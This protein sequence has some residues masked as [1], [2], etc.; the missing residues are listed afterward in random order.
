MHHSDNKQIAITLKSMTV[1]HKYS[2]E[3]EKPYIN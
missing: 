2:I 1:T 3:L